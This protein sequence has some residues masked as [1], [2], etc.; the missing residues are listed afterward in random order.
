MPWSETPDPP[1]YRV[2]SYTTP[3]LPLFAA[4]TECVCSGPQT[5]IFR[6]SPV[7]RSSIPCNAVDARALPVTTKREG[8]GQRTGGRIVETGA[9][10]PG[11]HLGR[12]GGGA[13]TD[14]GRD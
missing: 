4:T 5:V 8:A 9:G 1:S 3:E 14:L 10:V 2:E 6:V 12:L 13:L 7:C 11:A